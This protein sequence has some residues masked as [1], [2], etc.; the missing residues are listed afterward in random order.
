M[1]FTKVEGIVGRQLGDKGFTLTETITTST[2]ST[3][4]KYW[5][6]WTKQQASEGDFVEVTGTLGTAILKDYKTGEDKLTQSGKR[7]V[8]LTINDGQVKTLR[9]NNTEM[10]F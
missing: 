9:P 7:I 1:A 2:G 5:N 4:E 3:F 6:V 10:P 8:E